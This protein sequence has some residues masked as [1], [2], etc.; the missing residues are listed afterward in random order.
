VFFGLRNVPVIL[1]IC[2][3]MAEVCP[4]AQLINYTNPLAII[5]W[6]ISDYTQIKNV[7]ICNGVL[8]TAGDLAKYL[9]IPKDELDY[10]VGGINHMA[11]FLELKHHGRTC[12][13]TNGEIQ[14]PHGIFRAGGACFRGGHRAGGSFQSI[15]LLL[16][17]N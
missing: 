8:G 11:W 7:G 15:R 2:R 6:A 16:H 1:D 4:E 5:G 17:G 3:D 12:T 10:W 14:K 13:F 9:G